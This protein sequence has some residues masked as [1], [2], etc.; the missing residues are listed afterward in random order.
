MV[1]KCG[2]ELWWAVVVRLLRGGD[3]RGYKWV[4]Y[5]GGG[6]VDG[7]VTRMLEEY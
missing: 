1:G 3:V 4:E 5:W 7:W 6:G 2:M